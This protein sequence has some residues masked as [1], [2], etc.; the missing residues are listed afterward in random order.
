MVDIH[1]LEPGDKVQICN[2]FSEEALSRS[3]PRMLEYCGDIVTVLSVHTDAGESD[4]YIFIEEDQGTRYPEEY[5]PT[6]GNCWYWYPSMLDRIVSK[7]QSI[8]ASDMP[9]DALFS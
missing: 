7:A 8:S 5:G 2:G 3:D 9:L 4:N 6:E 1:E